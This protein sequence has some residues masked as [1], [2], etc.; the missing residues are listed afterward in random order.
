M[1]TIA[2]VKAMLAAHPGPIMNG[3]ELAVGTL[4]RFDGVE[5]EYKLHGG[6]NIQLANACDDL[7]GAFNLELLSYISSQKSAGVDVNQLMNSVQLDDAHWQWLAKSFH[8]HS[9]D[10]RWFFL[11]A[12]GQPQGACLIYFPKDSAIDGQNIFYIE[13]VATAPWNRQNPIAERRFKGVGK[14]LVDFARDYGV[15]QLGLRY[16]YCLHALPKAIPFYLS[17]GMV[18]F[19]IRDKDGLPYFEL[20]P[21]AGIP[22][23]GVTNGV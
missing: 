11:I 15:Q 13:Y 16:G 21:P 12:D 14:L 9:D 1:I 18:A 2:D 4:K 7:W 22:A 19:P 5:V 10:F 20:P 8:Y 6:W 23:N 3:P 17:V